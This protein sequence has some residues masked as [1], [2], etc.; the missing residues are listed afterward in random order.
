MSHAQRWSYPTDLTD[1]QRKILEP[2]IPPAK[3]GGRPR[4]VDMREVINTLLYQARTGCQWD[5]L[6]NDLLAKSTVYEYFSKGRETEPG[7]NSSMPFARKCE[8]AKRRA[9]RRMRAP[10][11]IDSQTVK[12]TEVGGKRGYDGGKK[13]QGRKRHVVF[14]SLGL[15]MAVAVTSAAVDDVVAAPLVLEH[16]SR[17]SAPRLEVVWGDGKYHNH[18]LHHWL[19]ER[20]AERTHRWRLE[21]V[22]RPPDRKGFV[23]L[24]LSCCPSA[25]S[26]SEV[27]AGWNAPAG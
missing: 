11:V 20:R 3:P 17:Q 1:D 23:L 9:D 8:R 12:T 21:I 18:V 22:G 7:R 26:P 24:V 10:R 16:L 27:L 6:P 2:M 5:M 19:G 4:S 13:I 25:G 15:L 14:D